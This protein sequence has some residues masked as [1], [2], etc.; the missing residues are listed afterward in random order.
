M[1]IVLLFILIILG[2]LVLVFLSLDEVNLSYSCF[3]LVFMMIQTL[4]ASSKTHSLFFPTLTL[5]SSPSTKSFIHLNN[6]SS[7]SSHPVLPFASSLTT[8]KEIFLY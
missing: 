8:T 4:V 6:H 2:F 3:L 5:L 1:T 7:A